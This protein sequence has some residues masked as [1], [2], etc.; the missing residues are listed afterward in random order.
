MKKLMLIVVCA[1]VLLATAS[2]ALASGLPDVAP[3]PVTRTVTN[4]GGNTHEVPCNANAWGQV[5]GGRSCPDPV[6]IPPPDPVEVIVDPVETVDPVEVVEQTEQTEQQIVQV[7]QKELNELPDTGCMDPCVFQE[8][9][10]EL[11]ERI[12]ELLIKITLLEQN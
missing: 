6:E 7:E 8:R 11:L 2:P 4:R 10:L 1:I 5:P 12:I 3:K 9:V